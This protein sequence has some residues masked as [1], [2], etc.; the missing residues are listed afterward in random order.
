MILSRVALLLAAVVA[1]AWIATRPI[2]LPAPGWMQPAIH[3]GRQSILAHAD[4]VRAGTPL[5]WNGARC[6][7][8]GGL[9]LFYGYRFLWVFPDVWVAEAPPDWSDRPWA[10]I[11]GVGSA[12]AISIEY[13]NDLVRYFS[14]SGEV[15]CPTSR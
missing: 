3:D 12:K 8:D 7:A 6:R 1:L 5:A 2:D 11:G 10:R 14:E 4:L 9:L 15:A 13:G